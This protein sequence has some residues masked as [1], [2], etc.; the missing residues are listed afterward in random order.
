M[1]T[2][3]DLEKVWELP[4]Y[5][6]DNPEEGASAE[7]QALHAALLDEFE[8]K[9]VLLTW[10]A[11]NYLEKAA[12]L[13]FWGQSI[14]PFSYLTDKA[15]VPGDPTKVKKVLVTV[16][17]E[18]FGRLVYANSRNKWLLD[19][20]YKKLNGKTKVPKY[21]K[22]DPTTEAFKDHVNKWTSSQTGQ[23]QGGGWSCWNYP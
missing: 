2:V 1:P 4:D 22:N 11:D 19:M 18:A 21:N 23:V 16:T 3:E 6:G 7:D 10:Y 9:K 13:E 14:R 17:S 15:E 5:P 8:K 20:K 12:G